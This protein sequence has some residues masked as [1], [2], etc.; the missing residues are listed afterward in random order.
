MCSRSAVSLRRGPAAL[1]RVGAA[2]AF[3][4]LALSACASDPARQATP[5][6]PS[7]LP[8][9]EVYFYPARGQSAEEQERDRYECY[10]WAM[11]Q[12]GFDPS[13]PQLLPHQR[14]EVVASRPAGETAAAGAAAGAVLGAVLSPR[15]RQAEGAVFGAVTGAMVGVA[16]EAARQ[17]QAEQTQQRRRSEQIEQQAANYRRAM[18]AC[19]EGRGYSVR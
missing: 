14:L 2:V 16:A 17:E 1:C 8:S 6:S 11:R 5:V 19:L 9:T 12:T 13:Q 3:V 18:T 7:A 15:G 10:L 4:S